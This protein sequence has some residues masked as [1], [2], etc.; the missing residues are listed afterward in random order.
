MEDLR[1]RILSSLFHHRGVLRST[2]IHHYGVNPHPSREVSTMSSQSSQDEPFSQFTQGPSG[3]LPSTFRFLAWQNRRIVRLL[4]WGYPA[5][6]VAKIFNLSTAAV[7]RIRR[8]KTQ[9]GCSQPLRCLGCPVSQL[10]KEVKK[11]IRHHICRDPLI[12]VADLARKN[13]I[14]RLTVWCCLCVMGLKSL[15]RH[16]CH[17]LMEKQQAW[18]FRGAWHILGLPKK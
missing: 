13:N 1:K 16:C 12:S 2:A 6:E 10:G 8:R 11:R 4:W 18:R 15:V 3:R 7:N 5:G 9:T 14:S 17:V